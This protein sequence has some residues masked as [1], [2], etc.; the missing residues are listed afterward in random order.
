MPGDR[1][2][3]LLRASQRAT[4]SDFIRTLKE[5]LCGCRPFVTI[6][7]CDRTVFAL[8]K[9]ARAPSQAKSAHATYTAASC[10]PSES[11]DTWRQSPTSF[12]VLPNRRY[13]SS[14]VVDGGMPAEEI[15][16]KRGPLIFGNGR[17]VNIG[18]LGKTDAT[19]LPVQL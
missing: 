15:K 5:N 4:A 9:P 16:Q 13:R 10:L 8:A 14:P 19:P 11:E 12:G 6:E 1:S 2:F 17:R 3:A 18:L 7:D